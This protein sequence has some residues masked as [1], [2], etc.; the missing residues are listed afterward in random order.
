MRKNRGEQQ[1]RLRRPRTKLSWGRGGWVGV[2]GKKE[3]EGMSDSGSRKT[4]RPGGGMQNGVGGE[5]DGEY[6]KALRLKGGVKGPWEQ[7]G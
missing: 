2:M 3:K 5:G 7:V 1:E 6:K 4:V